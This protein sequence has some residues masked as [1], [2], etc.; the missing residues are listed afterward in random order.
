MKIRVFSVFDTKA[1]AFLPP[2]FMP[3]QGQALRIFTDAVNKPDHQFHAHPEDYALYDIGD[4]DDSKGILTPCNPDLL[5]TG[6]SVVDSVAAADKPPF[7]L[8]GD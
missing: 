2:F 4:F 5:I 8:V 6:L 3:E 1:K 7:E